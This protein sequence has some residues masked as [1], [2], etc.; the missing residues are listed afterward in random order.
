MKRECETVTLASRMSSIGTANNVFA[1]TGSDEI[2]DGVK[3]V[4]G[5]TRLSELPRANL[6][7][8]CVRCPHPGVG[9]RGL[10]VN[11]VFVDGIGA[12]TAHVAA[13]RNSPLFVLAA[14]S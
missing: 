8:A 13:A 6:V 14:R 9:K 11:S 3:K 1:R 4:Y 2:Q 5:P 10:F 7:P 12:D